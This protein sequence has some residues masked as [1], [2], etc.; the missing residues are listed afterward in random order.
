[1]RFDVL[2]TVLFADFIAP[3]LLA[4]EQAQHFDLH[5]LPAVAVL[6]ALA[7]VSVTLLI[8]QERR[9]AEPLLPIQ[10]F[11]QAGDL[12]DRPDGACVAAQTV[13]LVS[14]LPI[15]L[16]VVRNAGTAEAGLAWSGAS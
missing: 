5:V 15:Y 14:F 6:L 8:R 16:Q 1:M 9:T 2:G 11:R 7:I 12:A 3:L 4:M 13:S 10:L